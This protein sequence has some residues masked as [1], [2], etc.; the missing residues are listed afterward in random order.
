MSSDKELIPI[1]GTNN[2]YQLREESN[3]YQYG[4]GSRIPRAVFPDSF[5]QSAEDPEEEDPEETLAS[6][7]TDQQLELE[8]SHSK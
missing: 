6:Y 3:I 7:N 1:P 8:P 5:V 4:N 2:K